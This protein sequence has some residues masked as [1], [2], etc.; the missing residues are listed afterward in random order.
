MDASLIGQIAQQGLLGVICVILLWVVKTLWSENKALQA[1]RLEDKDVHLEDT[2]SAMASV[3]SAVDTVKA[4][5]SA[6][7]T[8][9]GK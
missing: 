2:K 8:L 6:L 3:T 4:T 1:A 7:Q 5:I 9:S